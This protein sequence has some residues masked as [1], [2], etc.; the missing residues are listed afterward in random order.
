MTDFRTQTD[1]VAKPPSKTVR[2]LFCFVLIPSF[3]ALLNILRGSVYAPSLSFV[4][5]VLI[6]LP[7]A[8]FGWTIAGIL[9]AGI[10]ELT[11]AR[12]LPATILATV[13][14]VLLMTVANYYA[15]SEY[16]YEMHNR[17]PWLDSLFQGSVPIFASSLPAFMMSPSALYGYTTL[18]IAHTGY[19]ILVPGSRYLGD[20]P[21][22]VESRTQRVNNSPDPP[23]PGPVGPALKTVSPANEASLPRAAFMGRLLPAL[24]RDLILLSAEEHYIRVVT[25]LG[26]DIVLYRLS[27]AIDEL[28]DYDGDQVHRSY[29]IAWNEVAEIQKEGRSFRLLMSSGERV[30]V[31]RSHRGLVAKRLRDREEILRSTPLDHT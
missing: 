15:F 5:R 25:R 9:I 4:D 20:A 3:F 10:V 30:P 16:F 18:A 23:A 2:L 19:R 13:I 11:N 6:F 27:D 21:R 22:P 8:L 7:C 24:G 29:W 17:W 26:S 12:S 31:S 1:F 14:G 28:S